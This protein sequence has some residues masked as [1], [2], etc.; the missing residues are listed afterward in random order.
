MG[1][2]KNRICLP[3][4]GV[5]LAADGKP[6]GWRPAAEANR[7]AGTGK[8]PA[9]A[10]PVVPAPVIASAADKEVKG[11]VVK[12]DL[13]E[14][15]LVVKTADGEKTYDVNAETKFVGPKG[16]ASEAGLKDDRLVAGTEVKLVVI[17]GNNKTA[18]EVHLPVRKKDK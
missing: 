8:R 12:G 18:L 3:Q 10:A 14:R 16:G 15:K 1:L 6:V 13:K 4:P 7:R 9:S 2:C 11:T 17:A 5:L